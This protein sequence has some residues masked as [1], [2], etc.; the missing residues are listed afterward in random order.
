MDTSSSKLCLTPPLRAASTAPS[1]C[2]STKRSLRKACVSFI[3][4]LQHENDPHGDGRRG[5]R[6]HSHD[7]S[8]DDRGGD[9]AG[10]GA[11]DSE[12]H[13]PKLVTKGVSELVE[14]VIKL[15]RHACRV[16]NV[17]PADA[18]V[19]E[20]VPVEDHDPKLVTKGVSELVD[21]VIKLRRHACR[22]ANVEPADASVVEMVPVED[23]DPKLVTK[24]V[25]ELVDVVL[26]LRRHAC[27]VANVEPPCLKWFP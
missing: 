26:K 2:S 7:L 25:S 8:A 22:V 27:R 18:S 20:M 6:E 11:C 17:E 21:V 13:D 19:V 3:T 12:D 1:Y 9:K 4:G 5:G 15:R 23:H 14:I 16:A 24:D 10:H